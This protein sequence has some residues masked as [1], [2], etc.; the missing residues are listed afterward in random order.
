MVCAKTDNPTSGSINQTALLKVLKLELQ[1]WA[2]IKTEDV[3]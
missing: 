2:G 3:P 1:I